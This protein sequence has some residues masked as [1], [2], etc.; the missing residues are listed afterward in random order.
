MAYEGDLGRRKLA[1]MG[2]EPL[3]DTTP[4]A[5]APETLPA[6]ADSDDELDEIILMPPG[7]FGDGAPS[8]QASRASYFL[9]VSL[10][11]LWMQTTPA[12][13]WSPPGAIPG[14]VGHPGRPQAIDTAMGCHHTFPSPTV[15]SLLLRW[16]QWRRPRSSIALRIRNVR[17]CSPAT[18]SVRKRAV[19][20][21]TDARSA[22]AAAN[23]YC[24]RTVPTPA[25]GTLSDTSRC[26]P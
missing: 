2:L 9:Q 5:P 7:G 25:Y 26:R 21:T 23:A 4:P 20:T 10:N 19:A 18:A 22:C 17:E 15:A 16:L 24:A 11:P 8:A 13:L 12:A 14:A 6:A 3:V 1:S